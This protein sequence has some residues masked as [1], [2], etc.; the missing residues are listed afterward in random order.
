MAT[1]FLYDKLLLKICKRAIITMLLNSA[2]LHGLF[3]CLLAVE[4][5]FAIYCIVTEVLLF[6]ST[7]F[8]SP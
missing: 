5:K 8:K 1:L 7:E 3:Y 2:S 4:S 6:V